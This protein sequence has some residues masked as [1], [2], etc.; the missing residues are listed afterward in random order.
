MHGNAGENHHCNTVRHN[1]QDKLAKI[2]IPAL[3]NK[4]TK[5]QNIFKIRSYMV[6]TNTQI[7]VAPTATTVPKGTQHI[8]DTDF[9]KVMKDAGDKPVLVDFFAEWC[10]PCRLAA[11]IIEELSQTY[12][13]K[14]VVAKL[15]IDGADPDFVRNHGVM[16]IPTVIVWRNGKEVD[17][18]TGFIGKEKYI[19]MIEKGLK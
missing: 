16:S 18:Q 3:D 8:S 11:P 17:R 6:D 13:G 10:G 9:D 19:E 15:D 12:A 7:T 14:A 2:E 4:N 1:L 5:V